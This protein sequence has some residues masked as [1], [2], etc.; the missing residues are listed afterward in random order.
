MQKLGDTNEV[1]YAQNGIS[2]C[3]PVDEVKGEFIAERDPS[4]VCSY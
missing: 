3:V 1:S 4:S 2:V